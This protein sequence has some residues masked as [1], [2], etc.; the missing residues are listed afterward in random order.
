MSVVDASAAIELLL[1]T[2]KGKCLGRRLLAPGR[3]LSAPHLIDV[4]V[5]QVMRAPVRVLSSWP[6][7]RCNA[8]STD[9]SSRGPGN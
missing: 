7:F 2:R 5:T 1:R 9:F 8:T 3:S 6:S 4:E